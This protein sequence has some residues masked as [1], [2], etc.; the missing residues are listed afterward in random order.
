MDACCNQLRATQVG[1]VG[2]DMA[3]ALSIAEARGYDMQAMSELIP[4]CE[5]SLISNLNK[6]LHAKDS[7][8]DG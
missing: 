2:I 5:A 3:A 6:K 1:F 7:A 8:D 4:S